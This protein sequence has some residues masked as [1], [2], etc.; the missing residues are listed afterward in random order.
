M[1]MYVHK[2]VCFG[3]VLLMI[4][5]I[6]F[7]SFIQHKGKRKGWKANKLYTDEKKNEQTQTWADNRTPRCL[8]QWTPIIGMMQVFHQSVGNP[9]RKI[10]HLVRSNASF[11]KSIARFS[12]QRVIVGKE[13]L[14]VSPWSE[15]NESVINKMKQ[16]KEVKRLHKH[17]F[18]RLTDVPVDQA[19]KGAAHAYLHLIEAFNEAAERYFGFFVANVHVRKQLAQILLWF[20]LSRIYLPI[21][22]AYSSVTSSLSFTHAYIHSHKYIYVHIRMHSYMRTCMHA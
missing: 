13:I 2:I 8:S 14:G 21:I 20:Y 1:L 9:Y 16:S 17:N 12:Q 18:F 7:T 22:C 15:Y 10:S 4:K 11:H 3:V 5:E 6:N 19:E